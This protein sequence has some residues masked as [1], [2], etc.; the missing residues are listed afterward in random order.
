MSP[1]SRLLFAASVSIAAMCCSAQSADSS[2]IKRPK[3]LV[4]T[5]PLSEGMPGDSSRVQAPGQYTGPAGRVSSIA[6]PHG[7]YWGADYGV[8][9]CLLPTQRCPE[10]WLQWV[11]EDSVCQGYVPKAASVRLLSID[12]MTRLV[13]G[14]PVL[15]VST[16]PGSQSMGYAAATCVAGQWII[17]RSSCRQAQ[18]IGTLK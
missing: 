5:T 7:S 13:D 3:V 17:N 6:C 12:G 15:S 1:L 11:S 14:G 8:V 16:V 10:A 4:G 18:G 2:A 9:V